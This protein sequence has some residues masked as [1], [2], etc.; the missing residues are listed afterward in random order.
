MTLSTLKAM[1]VAALLLA[2]AAANANGTM[3][4][5]ES[6]FPVAETVDRLV[7]AIEEKGIKIA[8]RFDHAAG[9][10]A[11]GLELPPTVVVMFGNP[12]LGTP[13][14]QADPRIGIDLP[15]KVLV[16]QDKAGKVWLG[17]TPPS[18]LQARYGLTGKASEDLL[19]TMNGALDGFTR[20]AAGA[21]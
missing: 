19:K 6:K 4:T 15:M 14:M 7:K 13:L 12:K 16:W 1:T 18:T 8:A 17:Y 3:S 21:Q 9:A 2:P 5:R 10:K 11:A 20:A